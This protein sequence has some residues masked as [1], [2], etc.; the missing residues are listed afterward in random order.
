MLCHSGDEM[1]VRVLCH[2][3]DEM[4]VCVMSFC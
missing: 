3:G 2:S 1:G 4:G